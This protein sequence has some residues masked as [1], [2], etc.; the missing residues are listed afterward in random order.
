MLTQ[1]SAPPSNHDIETTRFQVAS[2]FNFQI[3][4]FMR[5][6]VSFKVRLGF[7]TCAVIDVHL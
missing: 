5:V 7:E 4:P 2:C 1:F 3:T 6:P